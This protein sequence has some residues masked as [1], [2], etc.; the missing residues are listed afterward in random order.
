MGV[1]CSDNGW[2]PAREVGRTADPSEEFD[3]ARH[4]ASPALPLMAVITRMTWNWVEPEG[5]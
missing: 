4:R 1:S 5:T 2:N 3:M